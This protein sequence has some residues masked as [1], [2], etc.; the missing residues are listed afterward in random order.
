MLHDWETLKEW[1]PIQDFLSVSVTNSM[2]VAMGQG[3]VL[4]PWTYLPFVKYRGCK[5]RHMAQCQFLGKPLLL[6]LSL[7]L[8]QCSRK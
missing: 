5:G 8:L 4:H 6:L 1:E 3:E 2:A 7:L